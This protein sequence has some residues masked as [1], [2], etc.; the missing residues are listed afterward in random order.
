MPSVYVQRWEESERGWGVRPD[1]FSIHKSI[2]DLEQFVRDYW[3][4]M[5]DE[6]PDE[7]ERPSGDPYIGDISHELYAE[8]TENQSKFGLRIHGNH[9]RNYP[10]VT[11]SGVFK[12]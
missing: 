1:G 12:L 9:G 3:L 6:A 11:P 4:H 7:Y 10:P 8:L 2:A 5:P